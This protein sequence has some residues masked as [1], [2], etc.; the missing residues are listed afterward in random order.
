MAAREAPWRWTAHVPRPDRRVGSFLRRLLGVCLLIVPLV[1]LRLLFGSYDD[2]G[3]LVPPSQWLL[4]AAIL[5]TLAWLLSLPGAPEPALERAAAR[6]GA[7]ERQFRILCLLLLAATL[8]WVSWNVFRHRPL[9]VD[10]IAQVFQSKIFASGHLSATAPPDPAFFMTQNVLFDSGRWYTQY[11]P[12]HAALLAVGTSFGAPWVVPIVLSLVGAAALY[13]FT[14]RAFD[15]A[16]ARLVLVGLVLCPFFW[17]MGASFMNH[18]STLA[19]ISVFLWLFAVWEDRGLPLVLAGA[20]AALGVAFLSRPYTAAVVAVVF[21]V[22][23]LGSAR[24]HGRVSHLAAGALGFAAVAGLLAVYDGFTTGDPLVLGYVKHWGSSHGLGF[25]TTPWGERHTPARGLRDELTDLQL[26]NLNLFEWP[27]P[28]LWPLAGG[29][30]AGWL[31]DRWSGRLLIAFAAMPVAYFFYWH[32]DSYLGP[33]FLYA[34]V[35]FAVP[36]TARVLVLCFR[37]LQSVEIQFGSLF[38]PV[39]ARR[40]CLTAV[41]LAVA[42]ALLVGIPGRRRVYASGLSSLKVD[43]VAR[44]RAAGIRRGLIFVKVAAGGRL[45]AR[46][47]GMG[48]AAAAVEKAYREVDFCDLLAVERRGRT[49]RWPAARIDRALGSL[50]DEGQ[51]IVRLNLN[52]DPTL[53]LRRSR[54]EPSLHLP[55]ECADELAYDQS[56]YDVFAPYSL[57]NHA[58]LSGPFLVAIDQREMNRELEA[59]YPGRPAYL[60]Y[61]GHFETLSTGTGSDPPL[62]PQSPGRD[63]RGAMPRR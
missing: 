58:D 24:R 11:P 40:L 16:T 42:W 17:F 31:R 54:L 25:H 56:G 53:R 28:A 43:L 37:R 27:V 19:F 6:I 49:D 36:L 33:R 30:L 4:G 1:P 41:S 44:A 10:S 34:T 61:E 45:I 50:A 14:R 35:A 26:L 46:F 52:G 2:V 8:V 57:V 39:T 63:R 59:M 23:G 20:G 55:P 62:R 21:A 7:A 32:R 9:M 47:R 5:A 29:L 51:T 13:S 60:Y 48:A 12:G 22:F 38:R 3:K 18:V 15:L